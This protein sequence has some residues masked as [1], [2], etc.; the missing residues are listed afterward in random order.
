MNETRLNMI[1]LLV[2]VV[3]YGMPILII[4]FIIYVLRKKKANK[5]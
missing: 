1:D 5:S 2:T 3:V 4:L